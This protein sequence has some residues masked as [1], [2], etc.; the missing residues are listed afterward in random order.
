M[1]F[2]MYWVCYFPLFTSSE[3]SVECRDTAW[4]LSSRLLSEKHTFTHTVELTI[5]KKTVRTG[6]MARVSSLGAL[7]DHSVLQ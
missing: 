4:S 3:V 7:I 6:A 1:L 2:F 5:Y